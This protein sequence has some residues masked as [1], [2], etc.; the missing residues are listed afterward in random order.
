MVGHLV[1]ASARRDVTSARK[2]VTPA[3]PD[4]DVALFGSPADVLPSVVGSVVP[5]ARLNT[6]RVMVDGMLF[7]VRVT[8]AGLAFAST[9]AVVL[10]FGTVCS[11][12]RAGLSS[13]DAS[14]SSAA[15]T[16]GAVAAGGRGGSGPVGSGGEP[17]AI[18]TGGNVGSTGG[19]SVNGD[20]GAPGSGG[21][22]LSGTGGVIPGTGGAGDGG[23][24][25]DT[26]GMPGGGSGGD[27]SGAG[28]SG[29]GTGGAGTGGT[30]T[31]GAGTGGAGTGSGVGGTQG[32]GSG[33]DNHVAGCSS[34]PTGS[35]FVTPTDGLKHCYWV[36][37]QL[38]DWTSAENTCVTE[39]GTLATILSTQENAFVFTL[40]TGLNLFSPPPSTTF[41]P[42]PPPLAIAIALGATDGK[43]SGDQSG[44]G[45]YAWV[46]GEPWS[47]NNW[48]SSQPDGS[49]GACAAGVDCVC[50]HWLVMASDGTWYSRS[51][52]IGRAFI[53]EA[54]AR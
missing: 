44:A 52:A 47:Y 5:G 36:H 29:T 43:T 46:T 53:C 28:G 38:L 20:G 14:V 3:R 13:G 19:A 1:G 26:G 39:G 40:A 35:S 7:P 45:K 2:D 16:G 23:Q 30:G 32:G 22:I 50:D 17:G 15:S 10:V 27:L 11:V 24:R 25:G 37:T 48:H 12:D 33:G 31:G 4:T 34:F 54:V 18:G 41:P 6:D 9:V 8:K 49:C 51:E 21:A 42:P